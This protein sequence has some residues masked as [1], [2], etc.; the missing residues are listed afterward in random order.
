MLVSLWVRDS[1]PS[2]RSLAVHTSRPQSTHI[3]SPSL[4]GFIS[5]G[6]GMGGS[7]FFGVMNLEVWA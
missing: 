6:T 7:L 2:P 4:S 3:L 5:S 1:Y